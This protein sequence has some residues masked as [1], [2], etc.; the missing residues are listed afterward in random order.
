M[1]SEKRERPERPEQ[2]VQQNL[3]FY[4]QRDIDG[5][6]SCL[7]EKIEIYNFGDNEPSLAGIGRVQAMYGDLFTNSP[8]LHSTIL[9]R[10][11]IGNKVIDHESIVGRNGSSEIIELVLIYEVK[12]DKIIKI[13]VLR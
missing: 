10:T 3:N 5:F 7:A 6:M 1:D 2:I 12:A 8:Q 11:I 4:N 13:T 9:K